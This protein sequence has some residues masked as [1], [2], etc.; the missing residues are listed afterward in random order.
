M[1]WQCDWSKVE[2]SDQKGP[3]RK[4]IFRKQKREITWRY[5]GVKEKGRVY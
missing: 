1:E 3:F 5:L 2:E 4:N